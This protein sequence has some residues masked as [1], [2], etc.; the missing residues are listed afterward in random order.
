MIETMD[1][2]I[3]VNTRDGKIC[4]R[5]RSYARAQRRIDSL[6]AD[7]IIGIPLIFKILPDGSQRV[8]REDD[9]PLQWHRFGD[10]GSVVTDEPLP[11]EEPEDDPEWE[12]PRIRPI[13]REPAGW[14]EKDGSD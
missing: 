1:Y 7:T 5:F 2:I 3:E 12:G 13:E 11:L 14:D 6:P 4:E 10:D 8:V 9:K